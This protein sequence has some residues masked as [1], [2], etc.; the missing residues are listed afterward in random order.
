MANAAETVSNAAGSVAN[1]AESAM[2]TQVTALQR[3]VA[4]LQSGLSAAVEKIGQLEV[5]NSYDTAVASAGKAWTEAKRQAQQVGQEIEERPLASTFVAL[6]VGILIGMLF[7]GG[8]S[9]S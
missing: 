4:Q 8:R 2:D 3:T 9:R 1:A 6:G 5:S 7:L